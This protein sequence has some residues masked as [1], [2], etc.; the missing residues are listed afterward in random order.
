MNVPILTTASLLDV[1]S[2][3]LEGE[4]A[5]LF[6][7]MDEGTPYL[8]R[9]T[10][11]VKRMVNGIAQT[12]LRHCAQLTRAIEDLGGVTR[13]LRATGEEQYLA[14]LSLKFLL[15]RLAQDKRESIERYENALKSLAGAPDHVRNL[16]ES[17]LATHRRQLQ[18]LQEAT[19][20]QGNHPTA[21]P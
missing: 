7:F 4:Q 13:P 17:H 14:Y 3:L 8:T 5:S 16:L 2:G 12:N 6:R 21:T 18:L 20:R 15:P 1:L 10:V 19:G 11:D 9:A